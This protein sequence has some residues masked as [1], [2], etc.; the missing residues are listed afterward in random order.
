M[1]AT[2]T[3]NNGLECKSSPRAEREKLVV[4]VSCTCRIIRSWSSPPDISPSERTCNCVGMKSDLSLIFGPLMC[5]IPFTRRKASTFDLHRDPSHSPTTGCVLCWSRETKNGSARLR[6]HTREHTCD[7]SSHHMFDR[8]RSTTTQ[9]LSRSCVL[10]NKTILSLTIS[11]LIK[12]GHIPRLSTTNASSGLR[13]FFKTPWES[14][15]CIIH[16]SNLRAASCFPL[17]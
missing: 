16:V 12:F 7:C 6:T 1:A 2:A 10:N 8:F 13:Q 9:N 5:K 15:V 3:I 11:K 17:K 14:S 4:F